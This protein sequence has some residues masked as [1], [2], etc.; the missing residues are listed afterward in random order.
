MTTTPSF[1]ISS[2]VRGGAVLLLALGATAAIYGVITNPERAWPNLLIDGF[3]VTALGVSAIFF[4]AAQRATGA[5]WSASLRRIPEAFMPVLPIAFFLIAVLF[6]GRHYLYVWSRPGGMAGTPAIAGRA[7]YLQPAWVYTRMIVAFAAWFLFAWLFRKTSLQQ[8]RQPE[9]ALVLHQ[10][11]TRYAVIFV[12]VFAFS[13]TVG[14]FDWLISADPR[15]FSTMYAVY[16]FAGTFVQGIAAVTLAVVLLKERGPM[17]DSVSD[18]QLHD[19]GKLLF[20]FSTF[21]AYIWTCQYLLIWYGNIPEEVTH[22]VSRTNGP[23]LPLF[24]LNLIAN[25]VVPFLVLLSVR[26]KCTT[27]VLKAIT[28]LILCGRWLDLYLLVAPS[29]WTAPK[30]GFLEVAIAAGY[31]S[32][33]FLVFVRSASSAPLVPAHDPILAYEQS[34]VPVHLHAVDHKLRGVAQ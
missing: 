30:I 18:H 10:K 12:P 26:A 1:Q 6:F 17:R 15:W 4:L 8:D 24:A 29:V 16:V 13:I 7:Q 3:Y 27:R 28:V 21:W 22:Y 14:A 19:L 5:R 34:H 23:W 9:Q 11:L 25:W 2:R 32:L 33:L 20:A 31:L